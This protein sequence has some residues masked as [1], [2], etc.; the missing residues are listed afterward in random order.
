MDV[1]VNASIKCEVL[2]LSKVKDMA[3]A[4]EAMGKGIAIILS[5]DKVYSPVDGM[6]LALF[7][8]GHA[9]GLKSNDGAEIL[10]HIGFD[11]VE[12]KGK[13]FKATCTSKCHSQNRSLIGRI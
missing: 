10:I 8:T 9:I 6:I 4:S 3:F 13:H 1:I 12:L 2:A 11:T 5:E 7:P